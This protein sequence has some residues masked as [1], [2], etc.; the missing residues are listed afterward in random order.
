MPSTLNIEEKNMNKK[1]VIGIAS[2]ADGE[3]WSKFPLAKV[4]LTNDG[5][6][7]FL[8]RKTFEQAIALSRNT[9]DV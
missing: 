9:A 6:F 2:I 7:T 1:A 8:D 3:D 5:E 4:Y